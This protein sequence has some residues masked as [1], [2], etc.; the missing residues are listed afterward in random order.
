MNVPSN[1][2]G[3][4]TTLSESCLKKEEAMSSTPTTSIGACSPICQYRSRDNREVLETSTAPPQN[5]MPAT[6][7]GR[8][9]EIILT[10]A[11]RDL[12]VAIRRHDDV[13]YDAHLEVPQ[14]LLAP[15]VLAQRLRRRAA[16]LVVG[17]EAAPA[18]PGEV[19]LLVGGRDEPAGG[20]S[21]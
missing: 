6:A 2:D 3:T 15:R 5:D 18:R 4:L 14:R 17:R 9:A 16:L 20:V 7:S 19:D 11:L 13:H 1:D 8:E 10:P 21:R 12:S